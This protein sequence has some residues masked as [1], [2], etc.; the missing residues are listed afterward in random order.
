MKA[1]RSRKNAGLDSTA[2]DPLNLDASGPHRKD[3][4]RFAL[5]LLLLLYLGFACVHALVVPVGQTGYQNAPDEAAHVNFVRSVA[6]FHLPTHDHPTPFSDIPVAN[7][8]EWHQP[9][10]YYVVAAPFLVFGERGVRFC[11][12]VFGLCALLLIYRAG[13]LLF[14]AD[15][16]VALLAVGLAALTPTHIAITS[17]VNN[18]VLLEVCFSATLLLLIGALQ[19]GFIRRTALWVGLTIGAAILTKATGLLLLPVFGLALFLMWR[20]GT[21]WRELVRHAAVTLVIVALLSGWWF[22]RNQALYGQ[23]LPLRLFAADFGMTAQAAPRAE[24]MGGWGA[25]YLQAGLLTF[26]SFWAVYGRTAHDAKYGIPEFLPEQIYLLLGIACLCAAGG[27]VRLHLQ[28]RALFTTV[29]LQSLWLCFLTIAFVGMSYLAFIAKYFQMQGR[30]LFPAMLPIAVVF[31]LA[32]RGAFPERWKNPA[33]G[34]LLALLGA[35]AFAF[36]RFVMP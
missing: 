10:L 17:T 29:Q 22:V 9:P 7:G 8:Y 30:Y 13:R 20:S 11:S 31:A 12:I 18:D 2:P 16:V 25:Y 4:W 23:P 34:L 27:M 14:P 21:S 28:R 15:R 19:T 3:T 33:S 36:L 32:F 6:S 35:T 24:A 26:L 1:P 5:P